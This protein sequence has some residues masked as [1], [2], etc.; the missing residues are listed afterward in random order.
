MVTAAEHVPNDSSRLVY[1]EIIDA[2]K[3]TVK[4]INPPSYWGLFNSYLVLSEA[5]FSQ[6]EYL[7]RAY[8]R[9]MQNFGDSLFFTSR[10]AIADPAAPGWQVNVK[11]LFFKNSRLSLSASISDTERRNKKDAVGIRL[12]SGNKTV[13]R[14]SGAPDAFGLLHLDTLLHK[15]ETDHLLELE[16]A[17]KDGLK[18]RIPVSDESGKPDLQFMPEG[19]TF[20]LGKEQRLAFKALNAIGKPIDIRGVIKDENGNTLTTLETE[21]LGM[22]AIQFNPMPGIIYTAVLDNG[23]EY[24]L[25]NAIPFGYTLHVHS[26]ADS[27]LLSIDATEDQRDKIFYFSATTRGVVRAWGRLRKKGEPVKIGLDKKQFPS[28]VVI[29]TLYNE[30]LVPLNERAVFIWH[31]DQLKLSAAGHKAAYL[32]RDSVQ[33]LL[34]AQNMQD[35]PV[36]GSF[37]LT[38]IDTSQVAINTLQENIL[39]YML[40][41][42]D[43]KG[44]VENPYQYFNDSSANRADLLML[45]QGWVSY[46]QP[47]LH[48]SFA[49]EKDFSIHGKVTNVFNKAIARSSITLFGRVGTSGM[50]LMDTITNEQGHFL[51]QDFPIFD[52]DSISMVIKAVNKRG[53]AFNVGIELDEPAYPAYNGK[54]PLA[55]SIAIMMDSSVKGYTTRQ[56]ELV[57]GFKKDGLYLEEVVVTGRARIAG[58]KNLNADGGSDQLINESTLEKTPKETLVEVLQRQVKGFRVGSPPRSSRQRYM[59]NS[60]IARFVIDG[61]DLEFFYQQE[62]ETTNIDYLLFYRGILSYFSA[63]D[64]KSIEVMNTPRYNS[65]YRSRFLTIAELMSSGPATI[66]YSFIEITTQSGSGPFLRKVP[67]IYLLKPAY[68]FIAK[69]FYSPKY[70]SP[71]DRPVFPD[72]RTTVYWKADIITDSTGKAQTSFYTSESKSNYLMLIQGTDLKGRFGVGY[73]PLFILPEETKPDRPDAR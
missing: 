45:T 39:S 70:T 44:R 26:S 30:Q 4:R 32:P 72:H 20:I 48:K 12:L 51:F 9:R 37:S 8:T 58:S 53:K 23:Y 35:Q 36:T 29:L 16:I 24:P 38:V 15:K 5:E 54:T 17:A 50:F 60:N 34:Q 56:R 68:P 2:D 7:L 19:G 59:V 69:Q 33:L 55:G 73:Q 64:I 71:Q 67:G 47:P 18:I 3:K 61:I 42:S 13:L 31:N 52:T 21:H 14:W 28:G 57:T 46:Q 49:Y 43:M 66:D 40:L 63:E 10:F 22:G 1:V 6:G 27:V 11:Q 62:Q 41:S 25:P 65:A